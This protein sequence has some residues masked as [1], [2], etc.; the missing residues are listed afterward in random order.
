[1]FDLFKKSKPAGLYFAYGANM[2][3]RSMRHRCPN[4]KPVKAFYLIGWRL[5]F[6]NH[7]TIVPAA[8]SAVPGCLWSITEDCEKSLDGFEGFPGYYSK[9]WLTQHG[10]SFMVYEMNPPL[11]PKYTP[12]NSYVNLLQEGYNDWDLDPQYLDDA[13]YYE[14]G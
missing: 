9:I 3:K 11:N 14:L 4:A 12:D 1:M 7:A 8:H 5:M 10:E 2:C 13:L 6:S